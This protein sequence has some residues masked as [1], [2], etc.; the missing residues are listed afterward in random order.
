VELT[1][2]LSGDITQGSPHPS[3]GDDRDKGG[4]T[5]PSPNTAKSE[6]QSISVTEHCD[7][8]FVVC[9]CVDISVIIIIPIKGEWANGGHLKKWYVI[10]TVHFIYFGFT[11]QMYTCTFVG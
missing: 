3:S 9:V 10:Y 11:R 5:P 6:L 4:G 1:A 7:R 8:H 2:F